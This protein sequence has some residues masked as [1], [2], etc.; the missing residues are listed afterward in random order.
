MGGTPYSNDVWYIEGATPTSQP[1]SQPTP[2]AVVPSQTTKT[3]KNTV[4]GTFIGSQLVLIAYVS[5]N[6]LGQ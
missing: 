4:T 5:F 6:Y 1:S 2:T 3:I